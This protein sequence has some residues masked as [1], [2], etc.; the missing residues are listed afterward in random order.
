MSA[1]YASGREDRAKPQ[2]SEPWSH[3]GFHR[4][5]LQAWPSDVGSSGRPREGK[6]R[7]GGP[8]RAGQCCSAVPKHTWASC[9][10]LRPWKN[11]EMW[12]PSCEVIHPHPLSL[13]CYGKGERCRVFF[14]FFFWKITGKNNY[15]IK[16]A[17]IKLYRGLRG[18]GEEACGSRFLTIPATQARLPGSPLSQEGFNDLACLASFMTLGQ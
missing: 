18:T 9:L 12:R 4:S 10:Q 8:G 11:P 1:A 2:A 3:S 7:Q 16:E 6:A 5:S 14:F 15:C 17:F 13:M